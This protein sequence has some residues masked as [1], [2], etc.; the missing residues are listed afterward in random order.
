MD[1]VYD[2]N[3]F[4]IGTIDNNYYALVLTTGKVYGKL[5]EGEDKQ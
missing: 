4:M 3:E 2:Y 1:K 5:V